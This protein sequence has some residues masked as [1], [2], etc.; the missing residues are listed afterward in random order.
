MRKTRILLQNGTFILFVGVACG[1]EGPVTYHKDVR[2]II[3]A[4]CSSC[5]SDGEIAPFS[6]DN[7]AAVY[8]RR[9]L[10]KY[11]V[12]ERIM[13]PWLAGL[14]CA[15]YVYDGSLTNNQI[16]TLVRWVDTGAREG[17]ANVYDG[18]KAFAGCTGSR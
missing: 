5:H 6:L 15:D 12:A 4:K 8:N 9:A 14:D 16:G 7:Y 13:P 18:P 10:I 2:P 17:K 3:E 1:T 11:V